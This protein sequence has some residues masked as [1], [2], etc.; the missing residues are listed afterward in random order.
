MSR[1]KTAVSIVMGALVPVAALSCLYFQAISRIPIAIGADLPE[2][3]LPTLDG[4][5][6]SF[7]KA[8]QRTL[9]VFL[10]AEC[11]SCVEE[12]HLLGR[13]RAVTNAKQIRLI[14]VFDSDF[15]TTAALLGE[16]PARDL[17][18][19]GGLEVR[20]ELRVNFTPAFLFI[21]KSGVLSRAEY[22]YRD[23]QTI[24]SLISVL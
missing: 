5:Y 8:D 24:R 18:A 15:Q 14:V 22:G 11:P 4:R 19:Y 21:E 2:F 12:V 10:S 7:S 9:L 6:A 20:R 23:E 3:R 16:S 1:K 13:L 17:V